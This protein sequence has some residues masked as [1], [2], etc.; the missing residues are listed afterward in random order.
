MVPQQLPTAWRRRAERPAGSGAHGAVSGVRC[1]VIPGP[2]SG[3][4]DSALLTVF[5]ANGSYLTPPTAG[6]LSRTAPTRST[7]STPLTRPIAGSDADDAA[8]FP[9][10][11]RFN[12]VRLG[13]IGR[14][15]TQPGVFNDAYLASIAVVQTLADHGSASGRRT[16]GA[17]PLAVRALG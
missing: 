16:T 11:Q 8:A 9:G 10:G 1:G 13:I 17:L 5:L 4:S 3:D 2:G 12:V 15:G 6:G 7:R 14:G